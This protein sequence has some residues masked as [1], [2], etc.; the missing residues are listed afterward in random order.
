MKRLLLVAVAGS[1]GLLSCTEAPTGVGR[2]NLSL[3]VVAVTVAPSASASAE[4]GEAASAPGAVAPLSAPSRVGP[5]TV[6]SARIV[7]AGPE[8]RTVTATPGTD[9]TIPNLPVGTYTATLQGWGDDQLV[10]GGSVT[11]IQ[12]T[13]G[14][15][16]S[17]TQVLFAPTRLDF[18]AI[19]ET[20]QLLTPAGTTWSS[21]NGGLVSITPAGLMRAL[22]NG[23]V[24]VTGTLG[25]SSVQIVARVAQEVDSVQVTP[26]NPT[27]A[28][29]AT[30]QF[31]V[32]AFDSLGTAVT[33]ASVLWTS[34]NHNVA[35]VTQAGLA[36]GVGYGTAA[37]T[38]TVR[39]QPGS[40]GLTVGAGAATRLRFAIEPTQVSR[41]E[42]ATHQIQIV[43]AAGNV[44]AT[45]SDSVTLAIAANANPNAGALFGTTKVA[46]VNGV[47]TFNTSVTRAGPSYTL[48]ATATGLVA[49]TSNAFDVGGVALF[50][51]STYVD[52]VPGNAD[53]EASALHDS[54]TALG[55]DVRTFSSLDFAGDLSD[56]WILALPELNGDLAAAMT[57]SQRNALYNFVAGGGTLMIHGGFYNTSFLNTL[58]GYALVLGG[59]AAPFAR[60]GGATGTVF[61]AGPASLNSLSATS[62]IDDLTLPV[63]SIIMYQA[64]AA[65][66]NDSPLF[67]IPYGSGQ[68]IWIGWDWFRAPPSGTPAVPA[69]GVAWLAALQRATRY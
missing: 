62:L 52:Y 59:G 51:N 33:G 46:A 38:A 23:T 49:D 10:Y 58:W 26:A 63:G 66:T 25:S 41:L 17:V 32:A 18:I 39:G 29:G 3:E 60:A 61:A 24:S 4:A 56:A 64:V 69:D 37:I 47:A 5:I 7:L 20:V 34:T 36:R 53:H 14:G 35:T 21:G 15:T 30:Q 6:D 68:I 42:T 19:N 43:D 9:V 11:G 54:Y 67:V 16:S 48:V 45:R 12:V 22:G 50:T 57:S 31:T 13:G 55:I 8:A 40:A 28:P 27:I 44:V 1:F 2:G 65:G